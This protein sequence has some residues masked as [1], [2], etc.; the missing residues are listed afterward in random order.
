MAVRADNLALG[1]LSQQSLLAVEMH[2]RE[3]RLLEMSGKMV[4]IKGGR[5]S[6]VAAVCAALLDLVLS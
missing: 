1:N 2:A 3:L 6:V 4:E 5:M